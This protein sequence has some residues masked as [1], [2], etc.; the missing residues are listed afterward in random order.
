MYHDIVFTKTRLDNVPGVCEIYMYIYRHI[1]ECLI[2]YT[3]AH[4][5][6]QMNMHVHV[7]MY[8]VYVH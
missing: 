5:H 7:H 6:V 1:T 3:N 4:V 2:V 8:T